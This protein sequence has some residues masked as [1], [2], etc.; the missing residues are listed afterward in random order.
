M[1]SKYRVMSPELAGLLDGALADGGWG[2]ADVR[3]LIE[4][5]SQENVLRLL[6]GEGYFL[7]LCGPGPPASASRSWT[8]ARTSTPKTTWSPGK[9]A[10]PIPPMRQ[11]STPRRRT[12]NGSGRW[13]AARRP[14]RSRRGSSS[15]SPATSDGRTRRTCFATTASRTCSPAASGAGILTWRCRPFGSA[16]ARHSDPW[17]SGILVFG[18]WCSGSFFIARK[19]K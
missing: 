10:D 2:E 14:S 19:T 5:K 13:T 9:R 11:C 7:P 18:P 15:A 16:G 17:S 3:R 4:P 12:R 6:R 1:S 8:S